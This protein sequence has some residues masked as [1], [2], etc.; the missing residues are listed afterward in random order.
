MTVPQKT[1]SIADAPTPDA[2]ENSAHTAEA[3]LDTA[4]SSGSSRGRVV[5]RR[6]F[7]NKGTTIGLSVILFLFLFAFLT[8]LISPWQYNDI[9]YAALNQPPSL[10]HPFGTNNIGQDMLVRTALGL[11]KSLMIGILVALLSAVLA[12]FLGAAAGYFGGA[13]GRVIMFLI[14]LLLTLPAFLFIAILSPRLREYGWLMLV[15]M[16]A[17][18]GWMIT[19]R[20]VRSM[21]MSLRDQEYVRAARYMG[22]G[23]LTIIRRHIIP[24]VTS[25]IIID[26]T[27]AAGAAVMTETGLSYFGFG[28]QPPDVS[29][30]NII[31][32][33]QTGGIQAP[34]LWGFALC[35]L[36][37]FVLS[38]NLLGDGLR[39]AF[40]P[41]SSAGK[42]KP[43]KARKLQEQD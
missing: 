5:L 7:A 33:G 16:I 19:A 43:K 13:I 21:T 23:H 38:A 29:I 4:A 42:K 34:W 41:T 22:I 36:V 35:A 37:I 3:S 12:G 28:V 2:G 8:P 9:D 32:A 18:F 40:D 30:G 15:I 20:V 26:A 6:L 27:I 17:A 1:S 39:D 24:Q 31:S 25:F 11:Q 10:E 14:D